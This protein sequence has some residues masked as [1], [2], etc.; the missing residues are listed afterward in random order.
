MKEGIFTTEQFGDI[1]VKYNPRGIC[2]IISLKT[3]K[4]LFPITYESNPGDDAKAS[5][6]VHTN[7]G[8]VEFKPCS[9]GLHYY[10]LNK[11]RNS[12]T[13]CV[14]T[15]Q[16]NYEGFTRRQVMQAIKARKLQAMMGSP[17]KTDFEGKVRGK[18][19]DVCPVDVTDLRNAHMIFGPECD[20]GRNG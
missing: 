10:D 8:T 11:E 12:E 6:K 7:K 13:V 18:L 5:F 1:P 9:K 3:M 15:V 4:S 2:N 20:V 14:Q 16:N 19:I 17:S